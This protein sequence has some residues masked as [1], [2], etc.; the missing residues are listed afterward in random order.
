M[1]AATFT[2]IPLAALAVLL[3]SLPVLACGDNE[4]SGEERNQYAR[5]Y[6][7]SAIERYE[8]QGRDAT[9]AYHSSPENVDG[10]W[11]VF[12]IG[13]DGLMAAHYDHRR[14][15]LDVSTLTDPEGRLYGPDLL[16]ATDGG[17]WVNYVRVNP[18][19]GEDERKYTWVVRHDGLVFGSG[20]YE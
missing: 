15:G 19:T 4:L 18:E 10:Q 3:A 16:A 8:E 14:I 1:I 6:V 17:V 11:Y 9:L 13:E 12:I 5:E 7:Q 20:W 2:R